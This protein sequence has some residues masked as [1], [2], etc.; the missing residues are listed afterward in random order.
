[1]YINTVHIILY[2]YIGLYIQHAYVHTG[3]YTYIY[4]GE[5]YTREARVCLSEDD[6]DNIESETE[7]KVKR[8]KE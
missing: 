1:M 3:I 6:R 2:T 7:R 8:E 4:Y 5:L